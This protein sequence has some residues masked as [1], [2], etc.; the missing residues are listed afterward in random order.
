MVRSGK[1]PHKTICFIIHV[2]HKRITTSNSPS[3]ENLFI[4]TTTP[5]KSPLAVQDLYLY[6]Q[7]V[8]HPGRS[9]YPVIGA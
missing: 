1:K 7:K 2:D 5:Q 3:I 8:K 6:L 9:R 4:E